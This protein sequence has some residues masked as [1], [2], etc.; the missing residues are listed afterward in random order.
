MPAL[1]ERLSEPL[2]EMLR[3]HQ[4]LGR[5]DA[6]RIDLLLLHHRDRQ[7]GLDVGA[8][9]ARTGDRDAIERLGLGLF[10]FTVRGGRLRERDSRTGQ[11]DQQGRAR[12]VE[13]QAIRHQGRHSVSVVVPVQQALASSPGMHSVPATHGCLHKQEWQEATP[14]PSLAIEPAS[15]V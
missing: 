13:G 14:T 6:Q 2:P 15:D 1:L 10:R 5:T 3:Y 8:L 11:R 12:A 4:L 9:D 7:L